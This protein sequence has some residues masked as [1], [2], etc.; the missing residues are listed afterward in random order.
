MSAPSASPS[1]S[2]SPS[3]PVAPRPLKERARDARALLSVAS[4]LLKRHAQQLTPEARAEVSA[5]LA[6]LSLALEASQEAQL[7][8]SELS[9][10]RLAESHDLLSARFEPFK[11]GA[12]RESLE[13]FGVAIA[14][15]FVVRVFLFEAFTIP[16]GS[17]IPTLAVGDFIFI[18]KVAY[19]LWNPFSG[20]AGPR[21]SS[22]ERGDVIVFDYPCESKD[23]I[24]RVMAVEGDT[25]EVTRGGFVR[26]NG[27]W[28][29][30][31]PLGPFE[32]YEY[33]ETNPFAVREGLSAFEVS[34][35]HP[36]AQELQTFTVLRAARELDAPEVGGEG[37]GAAGG[38]GLGRAPFEWSSRVYTPREARQIRDGRQLP[39]PPYMCLEGGDTLPHSP[40]AFPWRVPAGHVFVM[41]D[42]RDNSYDSRFWGFVPVERVKGRATFIWLSNFDRPALGDQPAD[43]HVR[44][45]RL[46]TPMHTRTPEGQ[47]R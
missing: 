34:I 46:F 27:A 32:R 42:N 35:P 37:G 17:M 36:Q 13:S 9:E 43:K 16:T 4:K 6:R 30:E 47:A 12:F 33:F 23:Y 21:W 14:L 28:S 22:P 8:S 2:P 7:D 15:A 26:I 45:E 24:K 29:Q 3:A 11:K 39:P 19:A 31:R 18:N 38:A 1:P 41:G 5:E 44:W 40:Y 25:V 20:E 10:E